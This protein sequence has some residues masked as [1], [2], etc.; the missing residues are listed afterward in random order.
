MLRVQLTGHVAHVFGS[1]VCLQDSGSS[2]QHGGSPNTWR[3]DGPVEIGPRVPV[4]SCRYLS[5][6]HGLSGP[7][8]V[9][10]QEIPDEGRV[11]ARS[12]ASAGY[13][14]GRP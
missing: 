4:A 2:P 12:R 3:V 14:M 13:T 1:C 8:G 7:R 6:P 11:Q 9:G 10:L 5:A